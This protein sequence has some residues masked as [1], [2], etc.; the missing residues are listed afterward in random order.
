MFPFIEGE[1]V[2][3]LKVLEVHKDP[4]PVDD[5]DVPVIIASVGLPEP[6]SDYA[7]RD[8][9][10]EGCST[11]EQRSKKDEIFY[12]DYKDDDWDLTTRQILP[13]VDGYNHVA[14]IAAEANIEKTLV[15][16]C[17]QNLI[18]YDVVPVSDLVKILCAMQQ[19]TTL[20]TVCERF[21]VTKNGIFD[22]R[23]LV[24]FAEM[25]GLIKCIQ[26]YPVY[27]GERTINSRPLR[28]ETAGIRAMFT[29]RHTV[30]EICAKA[31]ISL[32][33]LEEIIEEDP[34]VCCIFR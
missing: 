10:K 33:V 25:H 22:I 18:Y 24:V 13:F 19:G 2:M 4:P 12:I 32:P 30:E 11:S 20:S 6:P 29:G 5:Q 31:R 16:A 34:N 21:P 8:I 7:R 28:T 26:R 9:Y 23:R 15:K 1:T 14:K 27:I 17:I 3:N